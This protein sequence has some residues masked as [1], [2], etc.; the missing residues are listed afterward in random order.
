[1]QSLFSHQKLQLL[2]RRDESPDP[3][4]PAVIW[5][6]SGDPSDPYQPPAPPN[7]QTCTTGTG[8]EL[9]ELKKNLIYEQEQIVFLVF[10]VFIW[11]VRRAEIQVYD[12]QQRSHTGIKL[13]TLLFCGN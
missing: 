5:L 2:L 6:E 8:Q 10:F 11:L 3:E 1:M 9:G 7:L 13:E 12:F 4:E